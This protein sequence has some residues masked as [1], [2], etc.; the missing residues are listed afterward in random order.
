MAIHK[1]LNQ[2]ERSLIEHF[3]VDRLSFKAIGRELNR[4]C[5]TISKEVKIHRVFKKTGSYTG[6][7]NNCLHRF[8][9][10]IRH[11]CKV[12]DAGCNKYCRFCRHC[13]S[14][15]VLYKS[16]ICPLLS[17]PPYVCNGCQKLS[18]CTLEKAFYNAIPAQKEY[19]NILSESR[20]GIN[21]TET[22]VAHL[23]Q[24]I[25]PLIRKGQSIHHICVKNKDSIM[26]SEKTI[27]NYVN[28][29]IFSAR[30]IDLPRKVR[31]RPRRVKVCYKVDK[32]CRIGRTY[33]DFLVY[34]A[35][36]PDTPNVQMDS[37]EGTKGG[38]VLLT[39]MFVESEMMLAFLRDANDSKSVIDIFNRLYIEL[40]PV[41]FIE[42][43]PLLL[44]D[45]GSEFSNPKAIEF[46]SQG[47]RRTRI[48]YCDPSSPYQKG[49]AENNHEF[50]RRIIPKGTSLDNYCQADI[51]L[52]MDHINSYGRKKLGDK[53]PYEAF[54][55]IHGEELLNK[56]GCRTIP[57]K[58][59]IL[60]PLL[61]KK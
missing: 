45:N 20:K 12:C 27:Y 56:L 55:F 44:G 3:L 10:D 49:A 31:Y 32:A 23:E 11:L 52:M 50:I 59:I 60:Q 38:K 57:S 42:L 5:T 41:I 14:N 6:P 58:D 61:L 54:A 26:Y 2:E 53:S 30:N 40:G 15:C 43:F 9:C 34:M 33:D 46:D 37:V 22:E 35:T 13:I 36:H 24:I 18:R 21:I 16:Q 1:H 39:L 7:F 19:K 48:F 51:D 8:E 4:D 17:K 28:Y 29:N 25:S 47:N